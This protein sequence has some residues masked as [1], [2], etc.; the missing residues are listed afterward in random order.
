MADP[1]EELRKLVR[2][3]SPELEEFLEKELEKLTFDVL[4][5]ESLI[6]KEVAIMGASGIASKGI[7]DA[8][9]LDLANNGRIFSTFRTSIKG[10]IVGSNS[11]AG[12]LG[13]L[14]TYTKAGGSDR[15]VWVVVGGHKTCMDCDGRAGQ[16]NT[17]D[18]WE[19]N[20]VPSSGW[21]VCKGFCYCVLDPV[22]N[23]DQ[24]VKVPT[25]REYGAKN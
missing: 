18:Y 19:K 4:A 23:M 21:S 7:V 3:L 12:R 6:N 13:Q 17:Y 11:G 25:A 15:W 1:L 9:A 14:L 2:N 10:A 16:V 20:G 22:G 8:I 5:F 24:K